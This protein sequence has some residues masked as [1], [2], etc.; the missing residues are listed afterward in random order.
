M[1]VPM[2]R[3]R[4]PLS[5]FLIA[6]TLRMSAL[7][8]LSKSEYWLPETGD[9]T[10]YEQWALEIVS[11]QRTDTSS[12]YG[13]PG[14]PFLLALLFSVL[15]RDPFSVALIQIVLDSLTTVAIWSL[16]RRVLSDFKQSS[17]T[18]HLENVTSYFA[19][20][21][22]AFFQPIQAYTIIT[23]P[24][25]LGVFAATSALAAALIS[26]EGKHKI[27]CALLLGVALGLTTT[28]IA[29]V[30]AMVPVL[31]LLALRGKPRFPK[32]VGALAA[33][34]LGF[35]MGTAPCWVHNYLIA[36]EPVFLSAH[37]GLNF[38]LGNNPHGNGYPRIP[39][40]MRASQ[41][42]LLA[43]SIKIAEAE[44]GKPLLNYEV[45]EH[46][47]NKARKFIQQ[48]PLR[49]LRLMI[50]K[51][52]NVVSALEYDDI[53]VLQVFRGE[54]ILLPGL[55][56]WHLAVLGLP[57]LVA[58]S[59]RW[60][61]FR[62]VA[63]ATVAQAAVILPVF[64]TERYRTPLAPGLAI[65]SA[66]FVLFLV[67][68]LRRKH[69]LAVGA[70]AGLAVASA[71]VVFWPPPATYTQHFATYNY[72]V[73]ALNAGDLDKAETLLMQVA[74]EVPDNV[75]TMFALGN[76]W[77][78]RGNTARAKI[79]YRRVIELDP[80]HERTWNN[81]GALALE[82][83]RYDLAV[84][85]LKR[86]LELDPT[87]E[88]THYLLATALRERGEIEEALKHAL[89]ALRFGGHRD[90]YESLKADLVRQLELMDSPPAPNE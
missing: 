55:R 85:F 22:Y 83:K 60:P 64:V 81:L 46:W 66:A 3:I 59:V 36:K 84:A 37:S 67:E 90:A 82:E 57:G 27:P 20:L 89:L 15:G 44:A 12:F 56:F 18:Q 49:W 42:G 69:F 24:T 7:L 58:A 8:S 61:N 77:I 9:S 1:L 65:A 86:S 6:F 31:G 28:A 34:C 88:K 11:G 39:K 87:D 23:M 48:E 4:T 62:P 10:F 68:K 25:T 74:K 73:K 30:S 26:F 76:L 52:L 79:Y 70:G 19:A 78:A 33:L 32:G 75:E 41:S 16:A 47:A 72:G 5:L 53:S 17:Q 13:L 14:Y 63:L 29:T 80:G 38:Y 40:G 71:F 51:S 2:R 35:A 43:D 50:R 21:C 45:S 54:G